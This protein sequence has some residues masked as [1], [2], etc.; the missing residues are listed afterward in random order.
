[1]A[2]LE[3]QLDALKT[4]RATGEK[5]VTYNGKTVEYRDID[6]IEKAISAITAEIEGSTATPRTRSS[7]A[8]FG[9]GLS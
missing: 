1:M 3:E 8:Y 5:R 4:A 9:R 6:E 7:V 2:T